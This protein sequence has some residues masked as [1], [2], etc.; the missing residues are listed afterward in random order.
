M[1]I[2]I[3]SR[4]HF[5]TIYVILFFRQQLKDDDEEFTYQMR[6]RIL[7]AALP[8]VPDLGWSRKTLVEGE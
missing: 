5:F 6:S 8:F 2:L 7:E 3:D 4:L 1:M